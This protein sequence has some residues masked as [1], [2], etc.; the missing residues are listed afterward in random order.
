MKALIL[1]LILLGPTITLGAT[2]PLVAKIYTRSMEQIGASVGFAYAINT[3]GALLGSFSAGFILIPLL[4]K[5]NSLSLVV[6]IQML[7]VV[8]I[9]LSIYPKGQSKPQRLTLIILGIVGLVFTLLYPHWD[10]QQLATGKYYRFGARENLYKNTSWWDAVVKN[11]SELMPEN[12]GTEL[13]FYEDGIGGFTTVEKD[14]DA[15]GKSQYTLYNSGK[16]D[17]ST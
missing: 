5:E 11:P 14:I 6:G 2:F 12:S 7:T 13:V 10:R 17:A 1:F 4:G 16:A 15:L 8:V 9:Y 3:M